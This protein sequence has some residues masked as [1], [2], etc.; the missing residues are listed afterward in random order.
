MLA[1]EALVAACLEELRNFS[2]GAPKT[3]DVSL[4]ALR[5]EN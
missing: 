3:D 1:P 4:L 2:S 5:R